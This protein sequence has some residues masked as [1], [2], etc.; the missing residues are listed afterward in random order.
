M[1]ISILEIQQILTDIVTLKI[2]VNSTTNLFYFYSHCVD[3]EGSFMAM[4]NQHGLA[5]VEYFPSMN[6]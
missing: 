3:I 4:E 2:L 6:D 5:L 1:I